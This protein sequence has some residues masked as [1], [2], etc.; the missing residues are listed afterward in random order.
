MGNAT[1][2]YITAEPVSAKAVGSLGLWPHTWAFTTQTRM[3]VYGLMPKGESLSSSWNVA[4]TS[5]VVSA[6]CVSITHHH[7]VGAG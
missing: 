5:Q 6:E 2:A 3:S 7:A 4:I 1:R